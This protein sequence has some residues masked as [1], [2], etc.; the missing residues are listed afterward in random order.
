M[1]DINRLAT[2][3]AIMARSL[4]VYPNVVA[5][6]ICLDN[7]VGYDELE[8]VRTLV[9]SECGRRGGK[10]KRVKK[11]KAEKKPRVKKLSLKAQKALEEKRDAE[12]LKDLDEALEKEFLEDA[13][14]AHHEYLSTVDE[15]DW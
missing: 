8:G 5:R 10:A 6:K 13:E 2:L 1:H 7:G 11:P 12:M 15:R 4:K 9:L 14:K 3:T